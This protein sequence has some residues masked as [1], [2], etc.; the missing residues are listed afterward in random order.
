MT[1]RFSTSVTSGLFGIAVLAS[2]VQATTF[3]VPSFA[4]GVLTDDNVFITADNRQKDVITRL[5]PGLT[6]GYE[7]ERLQL[8]ASYSQDIESYR[9][10][11]DLDATDMRRYASADLLYRLSELVVFSVDAVH[12]ESRIPAELNVS[13]G[14]GEG[15]I[16]GQRSSINPALSYRFSERSSARID[17]THTRDRL[18]DEAEGETNALNVEYEHVL[19]PN[20]QMTYGYTYTH[21]AFDNLM[22]GTMDQNEAVHTPRIGIVH[23]FSAF[24]TLSAQAGPSYS[25]DE[26]GANV[27]IL[28]QRRYSNGQFTF[29]FDRSAASLVGEPGLVELNVV[30]ATM[31][32]DFTNR[33]SVNIT[34]SYS[35]VL[36]KD[37]VL[38]DADV[39]R[40]SVGA[41]YRINDYTAVDASFS[42]SN[43]HTTLLDRKRSI[44]R[45]VAM[46]T[47]TFSYPRRSEP[48]AFAR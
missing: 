18:A 19:T 45:N 9:D 41:R 13:S 46:L 48:V 8:G 11:P 40:A 1:I 33:F 17:Y 47:L 38:S 35:E 12:T 37:I 34:A 6:A 30:N 7:S 29:G 31:S 22:V 21:F 4:I 2:P 26:V 36:R 28:L 25:E 24:T 15:R 23:N 3:V 43:Q 5:S 14:A 20:S 44:P 39:A 32:H 27:A 10:N 16:Q 42:H